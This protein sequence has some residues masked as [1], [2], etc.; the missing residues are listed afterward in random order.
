MTVGEV[1]NLVSSVDDSIL[2][3]Y[4]TCDKEI[5]ATLTSCMC[6]CTNEAIE[7]KDTASA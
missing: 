2:G 6:D 4:Q 7:N 5:K 1:D 3:K